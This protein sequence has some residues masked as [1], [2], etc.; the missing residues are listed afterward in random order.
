MDYNL[1]GKV[2][3]I[4]PNF[5]T[6][7]VNS[8]FGDNVKLELFVTDEMTQ[9]LKTELIDIS[10]GNISITEAEKLFADFS[11]INF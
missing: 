8:D 11:S 2:S 9:P 1:Y 6:I 4:L 7:T 5:K 3:Y 10:N